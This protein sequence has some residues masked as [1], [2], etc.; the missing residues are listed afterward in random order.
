MRER[1][2]VDALAMTRQFHGTEIDVARHVFA[3]RPIEESIACRVRKANDAQLERGAF[4]A[5]W[6]PFVEHETPSRDPHSTE[7]AHYE[8]PLPKE[9]LRCAPV[10]G[11]FRRLRFDC[12]ICIP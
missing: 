7:R 3:P 9:G 6:N 4:A 1:H 11:V 5:V 8:A 10:Y 2:L 12:C